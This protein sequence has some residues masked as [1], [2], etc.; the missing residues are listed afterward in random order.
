MK[1]EEYVEK[2]LSQLIR[3]Y[4]GLGNVLEE[5]LDEDFLAKMKEEFANVVFQKS[6]ILVLNWQSILKEELNSVR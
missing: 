1:K 3:Y 4:D 6:K 5:D 2:M